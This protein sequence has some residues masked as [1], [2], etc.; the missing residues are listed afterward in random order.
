MYACQLGRR[1]RSA[2]SR[3]WHED[4]SLRGPV[5]E[6]HTSVCAMNGIV[7][8]ALRL[9]PAAGLSRHVSGRVRSQ[10]T[11]RGARPTQTTRA[12]ADSDDIEAIEQRLKGKRGKK[13][14]EGYFDSY[15][16]KESKIPKGMWE[17]DP[18]SWDAMPVEQRAWKLWTG[19]PGMMYWMNQ[20]S[21]YGAGTL[22]F[23]WVLFRLVF[24]ALGLYQLADQ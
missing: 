7:A 13:E 10:G 22:A 4:K 11:G 24:P 6:R 20:G 12:A 21:L 8:G 14:K 3:S 18:A 16:T 23:V 1:L 5:A 2:A 19:E 17:T 15:P 9:S